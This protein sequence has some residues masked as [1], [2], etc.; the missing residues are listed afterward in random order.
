[1]NLR[2]HLVAIGGGLAAAML[3]SV[4]PSFAQQEA[5][6]LPT[7]GTPSPAL[8]QALNL[9]GD[10]AA[11]VD[12][13]EADAPTPPQEPRVAPGLHHSQFARD[14]AAIERDR[15]N[16]LRDVLGPTEFARYRMW[17]R[18]RLADALAAAMEGKLALDADQSA[19]V[20]EIHRKA[21]EDLALIPADTM[22]VDRQADE[23][24]IEKTRK[25]AL[26]SVLSHDQ[27]KAYESSRGALLEQARAALIAQKG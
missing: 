8:R 19:R 13:I 20:R 9:S 17:Q 6:A 2:R 12:A 5:A 24:A 7:L 27:M 10:R 21:L 3:V 4:V 11:R 18:D 26:A 1:M 14:L 15:D 23:R 16:H 22:P 25:L